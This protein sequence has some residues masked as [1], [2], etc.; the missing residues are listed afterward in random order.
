MLFER[1]ERK[2][3][4]KRESRMPEGREGTDGSHLTDFMASTRDLHGLK[5]A[6]HETDSDKLSKFEFE[7]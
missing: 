4:E 1:K 7:M 6:I 5:L 3:R 2:A